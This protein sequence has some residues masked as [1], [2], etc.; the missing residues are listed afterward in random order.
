MRT[1][2]ARVVSITFAFAL[3]ATAVTVSAQSVSASAAGSTQTRT[4]RSI[5]YHNGAVLTGT[6]IVYVIWYGDWSTNAHSQF[7][8]ADFISTL[9]STP[10]F[11]INQG[12]PNGSGQAP[13][14][15]LTFGG[16][17][18]DAYSHGASLSEADVADV[19]ANA[20]LTGGVPL[21]PSGIYAVLTSPDVTVIDTVTQFCK[22]CC[23][24]HGHSVVAGSGFRY[25]FVG[26]PRRCPS[27][28]SPQSQSP[29]STYELG[30][31]E[32]DAMASWLAA[33]LSEVVTDPYD[34]AWYDRYGLENAEKCEGTYGT[35]YE[36]T[37]QAGQLA[38]ANVQLGQ[39]HYLLQQNWVNGKKGHCGLSP[40]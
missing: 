27:I 8:L 23:N 1:K 2:L 28:C 33:A 35:T 11:Q 21:D 6:Q 19:V 20:I 40:Q 17:A 36:V 22:T 14:G 29:N 5:E 26:S 15:D 10:Y 3:A 38:R 37:N 31:Y 9:G 39:R 13:S 7:V 30:S 18:V 16:G 4:D 32:A 12:Y 25:V 34:D 24:L